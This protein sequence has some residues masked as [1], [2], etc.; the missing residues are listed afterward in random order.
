MA[1]PNSDLLSNNVVVIKPHQQ[2]DI[3]SDSVKTSNELFNMCNNTYSV[4]LR[5]EKDVCLNT[6]HIYKI[7]CDML[8]NK[9]VLHDF[10]NSGDYYLRANGYNLATAKLIDGQ[11][12][13]DLNK[14]KSNKLT[15]IINST[16]TDNDKNVPNRNNYL[17][18]SRIDCL[19]IL[20]T[21]PLVKEHK[22][23]INGLINYNDDLFHKCVNYTIYPNEVELNFQHIVKEIDFYNKNK[24]E[25]RLRINGLIYGPFESSSSKY[26]GEFVKFKFENWASIFNGIE[27]EYLSESINNNSINC[28]RIDNFSIIANTNL[29]C[30]YY[31]YSTFDSS[32]CV[33]TFA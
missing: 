9:I 27:N 14:P 25:I 24:F 18:T 5:N 30:A 19:E 10:P 33:N 16:M 12:I 23:S 2:F 1:T 20:A 15:E 8:I 29:R 32:F 22:L 3:I 31:T 7:H 4:L 11:L 21:V 17:N 28:S 26:F 13:F 6:S